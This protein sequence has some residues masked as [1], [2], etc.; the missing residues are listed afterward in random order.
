MLR[1][2]RVDVDEDRRRAGLLDRRDRR[3]PDVRDGDD[4]VAGLDA[5]RLEADPDRVGPVRHAD[6][7]LGLAVRRELLLE[8]GVLLAPG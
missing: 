8:G 3:H 2:A 4:L 5:E 6:G 7:V 1:V